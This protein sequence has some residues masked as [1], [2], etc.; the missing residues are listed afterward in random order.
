MLRTHTLYGS[1]CRAGLTGL[2]GLVGL[3]MLV[4][5][6]LVPL[7][8]FAE[9]HLLGI[10]PLPSDERLALPKNLGGLFPFDHTSAEPSGQLRIEPV[11][12]PIDSIV[13][14]PWKAPAYNTPARP[15][16]VLQKSQTLPW[17]LQTEWRIGVAATPQTVEAAELS[18]ASLWSIKTAI[19]D[20]FF[21]YLHDKGSGFVRYFGD[22]LS[23]YGRVV[24]GNDNR[25][26]PTSVQL[27][28]SRKF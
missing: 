13:Q 19:G 26:T 15:G 27:G 4:P 6:M 21:V 16:I 2:A 7:T 9:D 1:A 23:V 18:E 10:P 5:L 8:D 3:A 17:G 28:A 12:K 25:A 14:T 24:N 22:T 20:R 11:A